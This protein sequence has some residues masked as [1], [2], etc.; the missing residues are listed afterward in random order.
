MFNHNSR[1]EIKQSKLNKNDIIMQTAFLKE[2][3]LNGIKFKWVLLKYFTIGPDI[4][5]P[6]RR[7][8]LVRE[9]MS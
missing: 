9:P 3:I 6:L 8:T 2:R 7:D 4:F 1:T 5:L